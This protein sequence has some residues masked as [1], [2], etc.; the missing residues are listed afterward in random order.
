MVSPFNTDSSTSISPSIKIPSAGT[1][2]PEERRTISFFTTSSIGISSI[3]LFLITLTR[4]FFASCSSLLNACSLPYS[5]I[6]EIN[7][8]KKIA[9]TIPRVSNQ[10]KSWKR[11]T[12]LIANA[13]NNI[14][15]I[16]VSIS[17][18]LYRNPYTF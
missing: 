7:D 11:K 3:L 6:D 14:F 9:I 4:L 5:D 17:I 12:T 10:S 8:A 1:L 16:N 15:I 2:S 13:I 18:K